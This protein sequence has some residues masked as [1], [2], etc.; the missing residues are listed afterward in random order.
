MLGKYKTHFVNIGMSFL[1][2]AFLYIFNVLILQG[3][4]M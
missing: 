1:E 4:N 2:F 3:R